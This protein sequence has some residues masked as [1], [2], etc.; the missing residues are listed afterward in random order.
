M[1]YKM[2]IDR[3]TGIIE[4]FME[5]LQDE[6]EGTYTFQLQD[7]RAT[8]H[9]TLVLIGDVYKKLQKEAEFQRQEWIRKQGPHFAEHLSWEVTG[10]CNVLLKCKVANIKKETHIVWYKDDREISV[11]EKH[12]FKDGICTLLITEFSRKDAGFYEVILKDDRGKDKS[13]LKLVDEAFK[14]LMS[15]VCKMIAL[16]A[17]DLKIQSTAEG[18]RLYSFVTYYLEDLKVNWSHKNKDQLWM[19]TDN[20][21]V[22][23]D[24]NSGT[25]VK[26]TDRVKSAVTGE[27]IWLQINE[28]TP[29]DKG[30]YVMELFDGKTG[31]QKTV[32]LSG[33]AYD[34]AFAEFQRLKQAAVAEKN[35]ARVVGGLPDVVTIQEGKALNLTCIVW[36]DPTPEVSWLKNEKPLAS[37]N[38]CSLKFESGKTAYLSISGVSTFDSGKYGLVVK[39]KFGSEISDFTISVFIPEEEVR[40]ASEKA[41]PGNRKSK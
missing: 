3:N 7:G 5:K 30:K 12:D 29:N 18:I 16:S 13:R 27:Q 14:E 35:R 10:E 33:Q 2:H 41:Q 40:M 20:K 23:F 32:D 21:D 26:Y 8:G 24:M 4:M 38:H 36:G 1:K 6:D 17:T 31:H 9:S 19:K 22:S 11:D 39:N 25:P 37:D 34:E 28:P 15:E